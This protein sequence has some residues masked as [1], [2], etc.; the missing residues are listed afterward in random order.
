[1]QRSVSPVVAAIAIIAVLALVAVVWVWRTSAPE[2]VMP[3]PRGEPEL[4]AEQAESRD[5]IQERRDAQST[6]RA[7][8]ESRSQAGTTEDLGEPGRSSE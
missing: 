1:V 7:D 5:R 6:R 8:R 3:G 2:R 4:T